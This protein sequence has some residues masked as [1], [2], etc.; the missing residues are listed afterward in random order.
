MQKQILKVY[1]FIMLCVIVMAPAAIMAQG[2]IKGK[3]TD[4]F[5]GEALPGTNIIATSSSG[6][7]KGVTTNTDGDYLFKG[8]PAGTYAVTVS[9][10]GY[11]DFRAVD[12]VIKDGE[13]TVLDIQ[14]DAGVSLNPVV[15]SASKFQEKVNEAP[16]AIEVLDPAEIKNISTASATDLIKGAKSVD[17]AQQGIASQTVATRGFNNI[18]S[19][20]LLV[21]TDNR[22][23]SIPSL[24]ANALHFLQITNDDIEQVEMVLGPGSALYGPN[25]NSGIM[26][27][28]TK[29]PL[30]STGTDVSVFGG[31]QNFL[32]AQFRTSHKFGEKAGLKISA[33]YAGADDFKL[34]ES[35]WN[36]DLIKTKYAEYLETRR[37]NTNAQFTL[38]GTWSSYRLNELLGRAQFLTSGDPLDPTNNL[39]DVAG[40]AGDPNSIKGQTIGI[41]NYDI[42][43]I[44]TDL[45]FDYQ[46]AE[47]FRIVLSGGYNVANNIDLTGLGSGQARDWSVYYAQAR[48]TKGGLFAQAYINGTNSG[49]TYIIPTGNAIIDKSQLVVSQ[50]QYN[51]EINKL[52]LTYGGDFL[53]TTPRTDGTINGQYDSRDQVSEIGVYGQ[54]K[55]AVSDKLDVL[56]SF[57]VDKHSELADPVFSPRFGLVY[58]ADPANTL[59]ATYNRSFGTP[60]SNNLWLDLQAGA[61]PTP[62]SSS[63]GLT[64]QVR[65][66]G[67][68]SSGFNFSRDSQGNPVWYSPANTQQQGGPNAPLDF[69]TA[70]GW[71]F[72]APMIRAG[73]ESGLSAVLGSNAAAAAAAIDMSQ[74][75]ADLDLV[76][77]VLNT[78]TSTFGDP[79]D[80]VVNISKMKPT[81]YNTFEIGYKGIVNNR[82]LLTADLY[83]TR[84]Y[85]FVGPLIVETPNVFFDEADLRNYMANR[86]ATVPG[87]NQTTANLLAANVTDGLKGLPVGIVTPN[88]AFYKDAMILTYRN[89]GEIDYT[90][91]DLGFEFLLNPEFRFMGNYSY[92]SNDSWLNLDGREGFDIYLNAP[93]NKGMIGVGY[94]GRKNGVS[95]NARFRWVEGFEI[96]SGIYNTEVRDENGN[97]SHNPIPSY[98]LV[99][100]N[101][102]YEVKQVQ[103]LRLSLMITNAL[104]N[105]A[106]QFA[107]TP[108][109]GRLA[110]AGVSFSF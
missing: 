29:S 41:R 97:L 24:R 83:Y 82:I 43:K 74:V 92:I 25:V 54:A 35:S 1:G 75:P 67:V 58:K 8:I 59:R 47:D 36:D 6:L 53:L 90:G 15:V 22:I 95:A 72:L 5:S 94:N 27:M 50:V 31:N 34:D 81:I 10:V 11:N 80:D 93:Q 77:R 45:R 62:F 9:Y 42:K 3:V 101:F 2:S 32:K 7:Q 70:A 49:D 16:A 64:Y 68:P 106:A 110:L 56:G 69:N 60:S 98:S 26:H 33:Q 71:A 28:I 18:F 100:L 102:G 14:M 104:D 109:I 23:G 108:E 91:L 38:P 21:L 78:T 20:S 84:A 86:L 51:Q 40:A 73:M 65:A 48:M 13:E 103:G 46:I 66:Q 4:S 37:T 87:V 63:L 19:G 89:F 79:I 88:E 52:K 85:D 17:V 76:M 99:D 107:G 61:V 55:Y 39:G 44:A 12:I 96:E 105:R 57:R 30:T